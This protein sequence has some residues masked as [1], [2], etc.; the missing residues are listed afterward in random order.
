[1]MTQSG[2]SFIVIERDT[3]VARDICA[4]LLAACPGCDVIH[5]RFPSELVSQVSPSADEVPVIVTKMNVQEV[6]DSGL[7]D[8]AIANGAEIVIRAG[9]DPVT[10][11]IRKGWRS[12][13]SPFTREDLS[14]LVNS[15]TG[16]RR[17]G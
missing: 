17:A 11:V 5:L 14:H 4:G 13:T 2:Y 3:F 7:A 1:M 15:L 8:W 9:D 10:E 6:E 16:L 12:L